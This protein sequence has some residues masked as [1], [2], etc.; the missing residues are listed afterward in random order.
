MDPVVEKKG[1][2][3]ESINVELV[4]ITQSEQQRIRP[5]KKQAELWGFWGQNIQH[6]SS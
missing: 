6:S 2:R 4:E 3:M 5:G 1:Q